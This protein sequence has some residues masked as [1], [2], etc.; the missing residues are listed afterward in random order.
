[1]LPLNKTNA[2]PIVLAIFKIFVRMKSV[3]PLNVKLGRQA[4]RLAI[5]FISGNSQHSF[6]KVRS[7]HD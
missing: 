7:Q 6:I 3:T 2:I 4:L 1:M 5:V